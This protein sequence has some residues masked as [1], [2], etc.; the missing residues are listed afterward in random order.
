ML[1]KTTKHTQKVKVIFSIKFWR[2]FVDFVSPRFIKY[3]LLFLTNR[4]SLF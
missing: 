1:K 2:I 4:Y 3:V